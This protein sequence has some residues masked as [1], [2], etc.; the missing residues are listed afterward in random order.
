MQCIYAV[1]KRVV[2]AI[3]EGELAKDEEPLA[4]VPERQISL[5]R[6]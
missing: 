4:V 3:D 1:L 2:F 6:G 5:S